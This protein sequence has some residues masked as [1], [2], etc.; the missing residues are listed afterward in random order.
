MGSWNSSRSDASFF[1]PLYYVLWTWFNIFFLGT[2]STLYVLYGY[3]TLYVVML[4]WLGS[5]SILAMKTMLST[6]VNY[7]KLKG[8]RT[9][10]LSSP[11]LAAI[12]P[13][14]W[15]LR[16]SRRC[17]S[18]NKE[19]FILCGQGKPTGEFCLPTAPIPGSFGQSRES[20]ESLD[21]RHLRP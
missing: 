10:L 21:L 17:K 6:G 5:L 8:E 14:S 15:V 16:S 19:N 11:L 4:L 9:W 1:P 3:A 12:C 13:L 7:E 2:Y 20:C 18:S